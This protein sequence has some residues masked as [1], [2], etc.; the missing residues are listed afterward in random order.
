M[1]SPP[2]QN[3]ALRGVIH[4]LQDWFRIIGGTLAFP[5]GGC[6]SGPFLFENLTE[7]LKIILLKL[8]HICS[9]GTGQRT[10]VLLYKV[11]VGTGTFVQASSE[12]VREA[13]NGIH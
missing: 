7:L 8:G 9:F 2:T 13:R 1:P 12:S 10:S 4:R 3:R 5:L 6:T 11:S